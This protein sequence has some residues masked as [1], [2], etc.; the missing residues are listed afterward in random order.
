MKSTI[1]KGQKEPQKKQNEKKVKK[2]N[3]KPKAKGP[4][5][6]DES[7]EDI[8]KENT[9][10]QLVNE[11]SSDVKLYCICQKPDENGNF[12][13][14]DKCSEWYH[15]ECVGLDFVIFIFFIKFSFQTKI[16]DIENFKWTC[17]KC[18]Q[19]ETGKKK[20]DYKSNLK[21]QD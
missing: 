10:Q 20:R 7:M 8:Q 1:N 16:G 17:P 2:I 12:I 15:F 4:V 14:C 19:K 18:E 5:S 13:G 6:I 11:K 21:K 3:K 9:H